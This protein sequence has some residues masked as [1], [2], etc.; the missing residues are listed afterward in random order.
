MRDVV[1]VGGGHNGL[2]AACYLARTGLDVEV[3]ERDAVLGGAVST[4]ERWPGVRVDRGSSVHVMVRH[5]GIAEELALQEV[6]LVYD[7]VE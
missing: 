5:T 2:I 7:D 6:G 4:V 1:V 3:I